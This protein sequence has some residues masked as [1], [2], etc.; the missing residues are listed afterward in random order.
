MNVNIESRQN[1]VSEAE[2]HTDPMV[3]LEEALTICKFGKFHMKLLCAV[4]CAIVA[5]L[6]VTTTS[7]FILPIAECDL[8]MDIMEKGWLNSMPF[9][10]QIGASLFTGFLVDTFG[11]RLFLVFGNLGVFICGL[12]EGTSQTYW[13]LVIV[14]MLQ[15]IAMSISY[16]AISTTLSEFIH[17][18]IRDRTL[19]LLGAFMSIAVVIVSLISWAILPQTHLNFVVWKGYFELHS[20]NI[21]LYVCS[22][23][24]L[25]AFLQFYFLP[26]SPKFLLSEGYNEKALEVLRFIYTENTGKD[27]DSFPIKSLKCEIPNRPDK[28]MNLRKQIVRSLFEVKHLFDKVVVY[29][30]LLLSSMTFVCLSTYTCLRLWYPQIST[31]VEHY[32]KDHGES[33]QFCEMINYRNNRNTSVTGEIIPTDICV[34]QVSGTE[35]YLN[36]ILLGVA[37]L[38]FVGLSSILVDWMGHRP[39][40]FAVQLSCA[41]CAAGLYF[42]NSSIEIAILISSI[43]A[44]MQANG[45]LQG[46]IIVRIFPTKLR[47]LSFS[48][49]MIVGRLGSLLGNIL[50]PVLLEMGCMA[51]FLTLSVASI[52]QA[53]VVYFLPDPNKENKTGDK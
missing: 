7:S 43:C 20:W 27:E 1:E 10:G 35:T 18:E 29:R 17:K 14:K 46:N 37:S 31:V 44:L 5:S 25:L 24:S 40:I 52:C 16:A 32:Y 6:T 30:L 13:M 8:N 39:L 19:L 48:I 4:F 51:P 47:T 41:A 50:F 3:I 33:S 9:F 23:W 22:I 36:S 21:Y 12:L 45:S 11:R 26:E 2:S 38:V 49:V 15:G 42:T 34:P 28:K 53:S